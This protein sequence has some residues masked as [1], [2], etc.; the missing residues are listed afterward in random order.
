MKADFLPW[1][2]HNDTAKVIIRPHALFPTSGA[3]DRVYISG[4]MC[5]PDAPFCLSD[6]HTVLAR[7]FAD[8]FKEKREKR[9][10]KNFGW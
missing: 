5:R 3:S 9:P 6:G 4:T 7:D 8:Y 2:K 10:L 1:E